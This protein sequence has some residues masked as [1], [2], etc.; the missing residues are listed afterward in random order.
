MLFEAK[1]IGDLEDVLSYAIKNVIPYVVIGGGANVLIPDE[2]LEKLVIINKAADFN[3]VKEEI[4]V[5]CDS[6]VVLV[7]LIRELAMRGWAGLEWFGNIPGSVGGAVA[8]NAGAYGH[9]ISEEIEWVKFVDEQGEIIVQKR[10]FFNFEYR[11]SRFKQGY[12]AVVLQVCFGLYKKN[13]E[14][15]LRVIQ[16]DGALRRKKHPDEPSCGS[17]FKNISHE[18]TAAKLIEEAGLK[19]FCVGGAKVSEKHSNFLVNTGDATAKDV[20]ELAEL[21]KAKVK[22]QTGYELEREVVYL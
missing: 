12:K 8:G 3:Y 4:R 19:G 22:E 5:I 9:S 1:S 15:L 7:D 16:E 17:F 20:K 6:G 21:I 2:G 14:E 11:T 13:P 18:I 10:D